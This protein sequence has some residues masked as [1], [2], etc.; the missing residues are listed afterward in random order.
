MKEILPMKKQRGFE[1][2]KGFEDKNIN[3][4]K[5]STKNSAGNDFEVAEDTIVKS[6]PKAFIKAL[7]DRKSVV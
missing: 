1:I 4:P 7:L 3:L 6:L 5:R 2:A